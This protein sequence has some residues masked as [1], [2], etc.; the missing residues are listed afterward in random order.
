MRELISSHENKCGHTN[1]AYFAKGLCRACYNK[2]D[3]L[4]HTGT[5]AIPRRNKDDYWKNR[6]NKQII[7][8]AVYDVD[9]LIYVGRTDNWYRRRND[10]LSQ[11]TWWSDSFLVISMDHPTYGDSLVAEAVMIRDYQPQYNLTGVIR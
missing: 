11:S 1:V 10:H 7:T 4:L 2:R 6:L 8:Y 9:K 3:Y 5:T